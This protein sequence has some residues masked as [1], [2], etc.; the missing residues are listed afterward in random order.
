MKPLF[1]ALPSGLALCSLL[2]FAGCGGESTAAQ[3]STHVSG[4]L[5]VRADVDSLA[6]HSGFEVLVASNLD[7]D[8]D[9]L[10][11]TITDVQ[12]NFAMDVSAADRGIYP[13]MISRAGQTLTIEELVLAD[14]D[15]TRV[16]AR[17]PL[18]GRPV[19]IV[20][21][22]N[23]A[24][25]AYK[26]TKA[27]YNRMV[28]TLVQSNPDYSEADMAGV[29]QQAASIY[30]GLNETFPETFGALV[31]AAESVVMLEGWQDSLAVSRAREIL[32]TH[33][34]RVQIVRALRRSVAR[35]EGQR[36]A[37]N[38]VRSYMTGEDEEDDAALLAEVVVAYMDSL[39]S[40]D[41]ISAARDLQA[42][43]PESSWSRWAEG[44][45][46]EVEYLLPG[47][48]APEFSLIDVD[49]EVLDK[50]V[51]ADQFYMLEFFTPTH[52]LFQEEL[53][54]RQALLNALDD[55]IFEAISISVDPD[56]A[57]NEA[58]LD[59]RDFQGRFV[60][61]PEGPESEVATAYN[62]NVIPTRVLVDPNGLI[63]RK[64]VGAAL[65]ELEAD[66][67]M[68]LRALTSQQ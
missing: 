37:V 59:G 55:N 12:G 14:G 35:M 4:Q 2:L 51:L 36:G 41:A 63:V 67:A 50:Q 42:T 18:D 43:Y 6:D 29:V 1:A 13:M 28:L 3:V 21:Q 62:V 26:N 34:S 5:T 68:L 9:T 45:I 48:P 60:F 15:S 7:G 57:Y 39:Q 19:R 47:L 33:P 10:A 54:R 11:V 40:A 25:T 49:G 53:G 64:Y 44:A 27:Q 30:W 61:A 66:L 52:P 32:D 24:W 31:A 65:E 17:F 8:V 20:S 56:S 46:Y 38:F 22:E 58:L 16:S 23:A